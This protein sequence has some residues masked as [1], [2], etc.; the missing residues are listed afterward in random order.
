MEAQIPYDASVNII[1]LMLRKRG[2][3]AGR[4]R[5]V[6]HYSC[7]MSGAAID[8]DTVEGYGLP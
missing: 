1:M 8:M 7:P 5:N 2:H 3:T 6:G 4:R